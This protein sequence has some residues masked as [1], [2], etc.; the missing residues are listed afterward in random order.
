M[1]TERKTSGAAERIA[2]QIWET[3]DVGGN[4]D[5]GKVIALIDAEF[6]PLIEA[7]DALM[8]Y[9]KDW[10]TTRTGE[11]MARLLRAELDKVK[12]DQSR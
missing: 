12:S 8:A 11:A 3:M 6:G 5:E 9:E 7:V 10:A 2:R 1:K 4:V